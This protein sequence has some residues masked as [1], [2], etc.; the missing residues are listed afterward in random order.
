MV[1]YLEQNK[2][3]P[4]ELWQEPKAQALAWK[5]CAE[6]RSWSPNGLILSLSLSL[7]ADEIKACFL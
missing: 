4:K 3:E 7:K 6:Q 1:F 5:P 2:R